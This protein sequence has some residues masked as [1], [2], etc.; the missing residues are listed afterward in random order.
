MCE[1]SKYFLDR[2]YGPSAS[3]LAFMGHKLM[4]R[5][6]IYDY[7]FTIQSSTLEKE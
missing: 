5:D 1:F 6:F 2:F 3:V 7:A 4:K